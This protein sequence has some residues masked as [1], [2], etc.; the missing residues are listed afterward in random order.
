MGLMPQAKRIWQGAVLLVSAIARETQ[1]HW[2]LSLVRAGSKEVKEQA[3]F[4]LR[5]LKENMPVLL[6]LV[7]NERGQV[8]EMAYCALGRMDAPE[9]DEMWK[10]NL[11]KSK[12][13]AEYVTYVQSDGVGSCRKAN[14]AGCGNGHCTGQYFSGYRRGCTLVQCTG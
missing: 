12:K 8:R 1:N 4:A 14:P 13:F 2:Y 7:K 10:K 3:V 9:L 5:Y 6:E 11:P